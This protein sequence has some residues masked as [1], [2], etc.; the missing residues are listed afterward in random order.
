M[1]AT[2]DANIRKLAVLVQNQS[3][4]ASPADNFRLSHCE[5]GVVADPAGSIVQ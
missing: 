2:G 3:S 5:K 4:L 1:L